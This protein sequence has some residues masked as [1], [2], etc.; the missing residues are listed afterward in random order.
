[1]AASVHTPAT[2][3]QLIAG[4]P[5][6]LLDAWRG[7]DASERAS[8]RAAVEYTPQLAVAWQALCDSYCILSDIDSWDVPAAEIVEEVWVDAAPVSHLVY[9]TNG[10][11]F[12]RDSSGEL[13]TFDEFAIEY[14]QTVTGFILAMVET[15][16]Q[17]LQRAV[18]LLAEPE[19]FS[20]R[21]TVANAVGVSNVT[22]RVY[23]MLQLETYAT[24]QG[25]CV[26]DHETEVC[27]E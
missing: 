17:H 3:R 5:A 7:M 15:R 9:R 14:G 1:M 4:A 12:V 25:L 11:R 19:A 16:M 18:A 23:D 22:L 26:I 2:A 24:L 6:E 21:A 27:R 20:V 10:Q 13:R 8:L